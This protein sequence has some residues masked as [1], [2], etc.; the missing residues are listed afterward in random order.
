MSGGGGLLTTIGDY[1]RFA[2][3]LLDGG[4][5]ILSRAGVR[6][7]TRNHIGDLTAFGFRWGFSLGVSTPNARGQSALPV[8]GFGWYGIFGTWFWAMPRQQAIVL[9]FANVLREDMTLSLFSRVVHAAVQGLGA[10]S[11]VSPRGSRLRTTMGR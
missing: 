3:A 11:G 2:Q 10:A 6:A 9:L 8:G 4:A 7:M 1:A 5:P